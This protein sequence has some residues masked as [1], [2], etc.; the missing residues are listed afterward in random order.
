M[1]ASRLGEQATAAG[2]DGAHAFARK[3]H[4]LMKGCI[5]AAADNDRQAEARAREA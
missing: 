3:S 5:V 4:I 2:V 1:T